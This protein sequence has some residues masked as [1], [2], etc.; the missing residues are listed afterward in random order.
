MAT[1]HDSHVSLYSIF[2][3]A[4]RQRVAWHQRISIDYRRRSISAMIEG[5]QNDR[6]AASPEGKAALKALKADLATATD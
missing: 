3:E 6:W 1:Q 5:H 4:E 2:A